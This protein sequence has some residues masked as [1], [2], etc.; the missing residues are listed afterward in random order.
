MK[1][2]FFKAF[3]AAGI[4][5][6][7]Q[8]LMAQNIDSAM[9]QHSTFIEGNGSSGSYGDNHNPDSKDRQNNG[10]PVIND[11][12]G[13]KSHSNSQDSTKVRQGTRKNSGGDPQNSSAP[14]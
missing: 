6:S 3:I 14:Q 11:L 13:S 4:L 12:K 2:I 5:I 7:A 10:T 9:Q 1:R 8:S